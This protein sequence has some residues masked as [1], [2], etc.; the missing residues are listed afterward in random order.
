MINPNVWVRNIFTNNG[1]EAT[2]SLVGRAFLAYLF[3]IAG[4]GKIGGYAGTSAYMESKGFINSRHFIR[5][6]RWIGNFIG[7]PNANHCILFGDI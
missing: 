1:A 2:F 7:F 4:W 3:I 5:A 6:W